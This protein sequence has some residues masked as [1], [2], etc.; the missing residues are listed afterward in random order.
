LPNCACQYTIVYLQNELLVN[1]D[2][3][4]GVNIN[5]CDIMFVDGN[6]LVQLVHKI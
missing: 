6:E 3:T 5:N 2:L 1:Y 4:V